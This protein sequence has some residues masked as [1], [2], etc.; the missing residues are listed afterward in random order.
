MRPAVGSWGDHRERLVVVVKKSLVKVDVFG[1]VFFL[2]RKRLMDHLSTCGKLTK[3]LRGTHGFWH[4]NCQQYFDNPKKIWKFQDLSRPKRRENFRKSPSVWV[5][6]RPRPQFP[7]QGL[8]TGKVAKV[9]H[10]TPLRLFSEDGKTPTGFWK[11]NTRF[12]WTCVF[13]AGFFLVGDPWDW[14]CGYP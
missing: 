13:V 6:P 8:P 5:M 9:Y 10:H 2:S 4:Q 3:K 14:K 12:F 7:S 11:K 1:I